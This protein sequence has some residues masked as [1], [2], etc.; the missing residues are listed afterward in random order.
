MQK[1][2]TGLILKNKVMFESDR[3]ITLFTLEQGRFN[4]LAKGAAKSKKRFAGRLQ[5][6]N[7]IQANVQQ[8][9]SLPQLLDCHLLNH[10]PN[11]SQSYNSLL[12]AGY[13]AQLIL[14]ITQDYQQHIQ[15]YHLLKDSLKTINQ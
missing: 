2:Q 5:L 12:L 4:V 1:K 3:L 14:N 15:A 7:E 10:F 13:C 6:F 11:L 9:N 8:K